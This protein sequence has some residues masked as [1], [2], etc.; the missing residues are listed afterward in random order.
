MPYQAFFLPM[1]ALVALL[2]RHPPPPASPEED[3]AEKSRV[4]KELMAASRYAEA[5]PVYRDL[6]KAVPGNPGLVLNLGMALHLAGQDEEALPHLQAAQRLL[7]DSAP[8][9]L[10]L[11]LANVRVGRAAEAVVP[12]QKAVELQPDS[13]EARSALAEALLDL[14]RYP[15]AER[16]LERL[17]RLAPKDPATWF[18]LGRTYEELTRNAFEDLM[19]RSPESAFALAL[20][21]GDHVKRD[22]R[23]AAFHL[24]RRALERDPTFRGLHAAVAGI[25]RSSGHADWAAVEDERERGL[26]RPNCARDTLECAFAAAKYQEVVTAASK[27]QTPKASYWLARAYDELA[28]QAFARL[29]ALPPSPLSHEWR[30]ESF[31]DQRK[32]TES[33]EE[34]RRAIALAPED[35]RLKTELAVTL[36]LDHAFPE[37][38]RTLEDVVRTKGDAAEPDYLLGDVLLAEEQPERAIPFLEKAVALDP[39]H[40]Y[41]QGALGRAYALVGRAGDAVPHLERGLPADED[42]SVREQLARA[43]QALG[44]TEEARAA[45]EDCEAFRKAAKAESGAADE[46]PILPP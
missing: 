38:Q 15:E 16:H 3:L 37:A 30:A 13:V 21:A 29:T 36:R 44:R 45:L 43:Y 4:G 24:Y 46:T 35:T 17:S 27:A 18:N 7:P 9:A 6:V 2:A 33:A 42:G 10:F 41:A 28:L 14:E 31:R 26:P 20:D 12:L 39:K 40:A 5:V 32:Y 34:W 23:D 1:V 25:Y 8:A 19:K 22:R 11:G